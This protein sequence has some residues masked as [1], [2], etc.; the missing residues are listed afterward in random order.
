M[1]NLRIFLSFIIVISLISTATFFI[2]SQ[3]KAQTLG[4][5]SSD[6][7]AVRIIPNP[8]HF[9]ISRWYESQG[10]SGSP[11]AL[12]VDGFEAIRDGRTVYVNATKIDT[13]N[14]LIYTNIYLISYNQTSVAKTVDIL[15]QIVSHWKF[16][17]NTATLE[18]TTPPPNCS[19][20]NK[21]C[22]ADSD[23]GE[24]QFCVSSGAASS[25]C[26]LKTI[27]NCSI[28]PDCPSGY[29]CDSLKS[30]IIR[31]VKRVGQLEELK[32]ALYKY[33]S[34]NKHFPTLA[35]GTYLANQT[36]S[37]WP[38]WT[39]TLLS[40]LAVSS[41]FLDP[42]NRLG[43]CAVG[44]DPKTCWNS[45]LN[46]YIYNPP[47]SPLLTASDLKL[48]SGSYAF[49]YKSN[50]E[51]S[52]YSLCATLETRAAA[53]NYQFSPNNA[54][55]SA[56]LIDMGVSA[57]VTNINT[58]PVIEQSFLSGEAGKEFNG[59][60][61]V[62][63]AENNPLKWTLD[64]SPTNWINSGWSAVP[65]LKDTSLPNQKKIYANYAGSPGTYEFKLKVEDGHQDGVLSTSSKIIITNSA[66]LIEAADS[67]YVLSAFAPLSYSFTFS[68]NQ[69]IGTP[70]SSYSITKI[71]GPFD[72]LLKD[73]SNPVVLVGIN[74][75][76]ATLR[77]LIFAFGNIKSDL[78][79]IY[80]IKVTDK[81]NVVSTKN[82]KIKLIIEK[83]VLDFSCLSKVRVGKTYNCIL[84]GASNNYR[85]TISYKSKYPL[86]ASLFINNQGNIYAINGAVATSNIINNEI[87]ATDEYGA[88]SSRPFSLKVNN[89]CGDGVVQTPNDEGQGGIYN[90]G[91]E[92]CD[93][94]SGVTTSVASSTINNQYACSTKSTDVTPEVFTSNNY[95]TY[96]SPK[97]GGG[98]CGDGYCGRQETPCSCKLDCTDPADEILCTPCKSY[99]YAQGWGACIQ[100][101]TEQNVIS[102]IPSVCNADNPESVKKVSQACSYNLN[103][104]AGIGGSLSVENI[105]AESGNT[106]I[107]TTTY[108][109]TKVVSIAPNEGWYIG[110]LIV[111]GVQI[112]TSTVYAFNNIDQDHTISATFGVQRV[113]VTATAGVGG[114]ISNPGE[115][116]YNYGES[117]SYFITPTI[118]EPFR[119]HVKEV[120]VN[121]INTGTS[122]TQ[123]VSNLKKD[124]TIS[125]SFEKDTRTITAKVDGGQGDLISN[126]E[127]GC[128]PTATG[129]IVDYWTGTAPFL[130]KP[131]FGYHVDY[132][133]INGALVSLTDGNFNQYMLAADQYRYMGFTGVRADSTI[134]V[135][136][137][138]NVYTLKYNLIPTA[139][140]KINNIY[141][142]NVTINVTH[143]GTG[144]AINVQP[145]TGYHFTKWN[146][147]ST[148]NPRIDT[149]VTANA[150]YVAS[151]EANY[152]TLNYSAGANGSVSGDLSQS[153]VHGGNGTA[154]TATANNGYRFDKW[155]SDN[156]TN[157][158][159]TDS[160]ITN[161]GS[162]VANFVS[163]TTTYTLKYSSQYSLSDLVGATTQTVN[164]GS[165]G[166][167]VTAN[168]THWRSADNKTLNFYKWNDGVTTKSR[169]DNNVQK[170]I[171][172]TA[173]YK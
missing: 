11:Q 109:N 164:K 95:C 77:G 120:L 143:G 76:K 69:L 135:K 159:R 34:T 65:I 128:T 85:K 113:K 45:D 58:A 158:P 162:F 168:A 40:N 118:N 82:F 165:N 96:L 47:P 141:A 172:V 147:G 26:A 33:N 55:G 148:S 137:A 89:Y 21:N 111:D 156:K 51:G 166:T 119:Y 121:N 90:D 44:Y 23:C 42:I 64:P 163:G 125:V 9:S 71:S 53:I 37:V 145:F 134:N 80:Q 151:A 61:N 91:H 84:G 142:D 5:D 103:L 79:F 14:K 97:D 130:I 171:S 122:T 167:T 93:G 98:F 32:G 133:K 88:S 63:D 72:L 24:D 43:L 19:I 114:V 12:T 49:V 86:L 157:N 169:T 153:V 25:S 8:N 116:F 70:E 57:S 59:F 27:K 74:K 150:N 73:T 173:E 149:N 83:P 50:A 60:I 68:D 106:K 16:N 146:D 6:A 124:S 75:Y 7:I 20:S 105:K 29:F 15:S 18:S 36:V 48:P 131:A 102:S 31:D 17:D 136:F 87:I 67:E 99:T 101:K 78:E 92:D 100:G 138:P 139:A 3:V 81:Q 110:S 28:D 127:I 13:V 117:V 144:S 66:P 1:K 170:N 52:S 4:S 140:G 108:N 41:N 56:C 22:N 123:S 104:V 38:S 115:V 46:K 39:Q 160:N 154:V 107:A 126:C 161:N 62:T 155:S 2:L 54:V 132:V 30:K 10:F 35:A 112:A 152:Y 129:A 94:N